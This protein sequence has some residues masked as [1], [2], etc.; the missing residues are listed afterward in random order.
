MFCSPEKM[1]EELRQR[2]SLKVLEDLN[3]CLA[4]RSTN[5]LQVYC[6]LGGVA[7][8]LEVRVDLN[9]IALPFQFAQEMHICSSA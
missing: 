6:R 8:Q 2:P 7:M 1:L 4:Y 5:W 3:L 9:R